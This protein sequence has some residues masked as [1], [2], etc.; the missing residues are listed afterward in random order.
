MAF[1]RRDTNMKSRT[2]RRTMKATFL[3]LVVVSLAML[4]LARRAP[5][6]A[7][8]YRE[9]NLEGEYLSTHEAENTAYGHDDPT[10][11]RRIISVYSFDGQGGI[12]GVTTR[13]FGGQ[14]TLDR[15]VNGTYIMD[16]PNTAFLDFPE[17]QA[18]FRVYFTHDLSEGVALNI[19]EGS[20]AL[21]T[22]KKR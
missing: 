6:G 21:R 16:S 12:T 15:P 2:P 7:A 22:L 20:I 18:Q 11:P 5:A 10:Y 1:E 14:I 13:S 4:G 17:S 8:H 9:G 19:T 3:I